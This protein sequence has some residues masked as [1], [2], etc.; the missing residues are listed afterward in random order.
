MSS[1]EDGKVLTIARR[2]TGSLLVNNYN[3]E[4]SDDDLETFKN[5]IT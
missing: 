4:T 5:G 3:S 1:I 2:E